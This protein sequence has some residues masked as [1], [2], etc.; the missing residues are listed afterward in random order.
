MFRLLAEHMAAQAG[1]A[2]V[3]GQGEPARVELYGHTSLLGLVRYIGQPDAKD[4]VPEGGLVIEHF[5]EGH[6]LTTRV[7]SKKSIFGIT[8]L[9]FAEL[10][11]EMSTHMGWGEVTVQNRGE[12]LGDGITSITAVR[13]SSDN[14]RHALATEC[15]WGLVLAAEA[16]AAPGHWGDELAI[17]SIAHEVM[18]Q[19]VTPTPFGERGPAP[20]WISD[21]LVAAVDAL[22]GHRVN[23]RLKARQPSWSEGW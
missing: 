13:R 17:I 14:T 7:C 6:H 2:R 10:G 5:E 15:A 16:C 12:A 22:V 8:R 9:T 18:R 3:H 4:G 21:E 20:D 11:R 23:Q 1:L 19:V